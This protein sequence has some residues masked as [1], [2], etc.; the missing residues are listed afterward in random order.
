MTED[1]FSR[2]RRK[3]R[4]L[5]E[6]SHYTPFQNLRGYQHGVLKFQE[7][8][9]RA[10]E[11]TYKI[12]RK[13]KYTSILDRLQRDEVFHESQLVH[14]WTEAWCKYLDFTV[15]IDIS[16]HAPPEQRSRH[17]EFK[18][19][20]YD[21][22]EFNRKTMKSHP[23]CLMDTS[24]IRSVNKEAG[25]EPQLMLR[26]KKARGDLDPHK[27]KW[28]MMVALDGK[29]LSR[30]SNACSEPDQAQHAS[31]H[32][33]SHLAHV[34]IARRRGVRQHLSERQRT[35]QLACGCSEVLPECKE[36]WSTN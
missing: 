13:E 34:R 20:R 8:H 9:R 3:I 29:S 19:F 22:E 11:M 31:C 27:G 36:V 1:M 18:N 23:D 4:E 35:S 10:K 2:I 16:H 26:K 15:N 30:A 5:I 21:S 17:K 6:N 32:D 24:A 7:H 25:V 28:L 12:K 33:S 14:G